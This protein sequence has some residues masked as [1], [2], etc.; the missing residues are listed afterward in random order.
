MKDAI[1]TAIKFKST[2]ADTTPEEK[3]D[4]ILKALQ[5]Q[6]KGYQKELKTTE[7]LRKEGLLPKFR[8]NDAEELQKNI[9]DVLAK[10]DA[11]EVKIK[12]KPDLELDPV[13]LDLEISKIEREAGQRQAFTKIPVAAKLVLSTKNFVISPEEQASIEAAI[14]SGIKPLTVPLPSVEIPPPSLAPNFNQGVLNQINT[15]IAQIDDARLRYK[16]ILLKFGSD[17]EAGVNDAVTAS[18]NVL[19]I[20]LNG[21]V[22]SFAGIGEGIGQG[23]ANALNGGGIGALL[24]GAAEGFLSVV[25]GILVDLGKEVIKQAAIVVALKAA[26]TKAFIDP[27]LGLVAGIALVVAGTAMKN[28]KFKVPQLAEGGITTGPTLATIGERNQEAIL[29]LNNLDD[30]LGPSTASVEFVTSKVL[31]GDIYQTWRVHHRREG[32]VN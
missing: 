5:K 16:D 28:F 27:K 15:S 3:Q 21:I 8:E 13:L 17:A 12:A 6:L 4:A 26:L 24:A 14:S 1:N 7:E 19:P 11:R 10:I 32:R 2:T 22:D 31:G 20:L 30:F 23:I 18:K 29:P 25:G 9:Q